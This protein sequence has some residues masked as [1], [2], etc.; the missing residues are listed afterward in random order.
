MEQSQMALASILDNDLYKFTMQHCALQ[1]YKDAQ[2]VYQFTNRE[3]EL[4]LNQ[5]AFNW[6]KEQINLM[7][8]LVLTAD[9]RE[10]MASFPFF[11]Q[12]YID[13]LAKFRFRPQEQIHAQFDASTETLSL[14][15]KGLW[16][17]T[18]L[19]EVPVLALISE[20]YFRFVDRDW[21][22]DGQ[23]EQ[24]KEKTRALVT[25]GCHFSEF[26][27][28]RRRDFKTHDIVMGAIHAEYQALLKENP[29]IKGGVTGTSNVYLAKKYGVR[30]IGTLAHEFFMAVSALEGIKHANRTTLERWYETYQGNLGIA[31]TDTFTTKVFLQDFNKDLA[32]KYIA[33]RQDSGDAIKF[34]STI[35]DHYKSIGVD[36]STKMIV[37]SDALDVKRAVQL[38]S[39]SEKAGIKASFGIGTSLTN[40]FKKAS[41]PSQ[42][43]KPLNIVIKMSECNGK[44]VIKLSDDVL[45]NSADAETVRRFKEELGI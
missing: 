29:D 5:E 13:Y 27:T 14:T 9:E 1:H 35:V 38:V 30:A 22:Y 10:Y 7:E 32:D 24:A 15:I 12:S 45:K 39:L 41:D 26:G 17:E 6:L 3:K 25:N 31:L 18:I 43:S 11:D 4:S 2:V 40:D 44:R 19:Y 23:E 28:R 20:A 34:I 8:S 42:K 21:T 37:F 33:V 36:P 16:H